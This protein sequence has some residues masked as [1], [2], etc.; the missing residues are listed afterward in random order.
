MLVTTLK[1]QTTTT[2]AK[3][4]DGKLRLETR[5]QNPTIY[6]RAYVQG[7]NRVHC[8]GKTTIH[9]AKPVAED[10]FF[11]LKVRT[12]KGE[13]L[14]DPT[15]ADVA[16]KFLASAHQDHNDGQVR[17]FN[18]KW[19]LLKPYFRNLKPSDIDL[20][21]LKELRNKRSQTPP[22]PGKPLPK[23]ATLKKDLLFVRLVLRYARDTARCLTSL[24]DFP[25]FKRG[26]K[27]E[28][29]PSGRPRFTRSEFRKLLKTAWLRMREPD[30]NPR[31]RRQ[32]AE[33]YYLI[34]IAT[35]A[36]LRVDEAYSLRWCDCEE[37]LIDD[38]DLTEKGS[39]GEELL[40]EV[41]L[42]AMVYGKHSPHTTRSGD[43]GDREEARGCQLATFA[44]AR[45]RGMRESE[46]AAAAD[47]R[48]GQQKAKRTVEPEDALF[49]HSHRE[50]F[51]RLLIAA[52]LRKDHKGRLRNLKS[53]R[54]TGISLRIEE[55][56]RKLGGSPDYGDLA[57]WART[58]VAMIEKYYDQTLKEE[59]IARATVPW[60]NGGR[61]SR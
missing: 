13:R 22:A 29:R 39:R 5:N 40:A 54:A 37:Y 16:Q 32:R 50:G 55:S 38:S 4:L 1:R 18:D 12:E 57:V 58:S 48:K 8:T 20:G 10:W 45:L 2:I 53:L 36:A 17:N 11:A 19:N 6:A 34:I 7:K 23:P 60:S 25:P 15:F 24:P 56:A 31:T 47:G 51:K 52:N 46:V 30:L 28:I 49:L 14:D 61:P 21:F 59:A 3:L 27:W 26:T 9:D 33:L 42:K 44:Y 43:D 41:Q 35:G